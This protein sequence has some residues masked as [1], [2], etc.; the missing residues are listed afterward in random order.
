MRTRDIPVAACSKCNSMD[1]DGDITNRTQCHASAWQHDAVRHGSYNTGE[2]PQ[3]ESVLVLEL[4]NPARFMN[5]LSDGCHSIVLA[6]GSL[7]PLPSLCAELGFS[8]SPDFQKNNM[9]TASPSHKYPTTSLRETNQAGRLQ[10]R[11]PPLEADQVIDNEK[12]LLAVA[13]GHF[14]D[15]SDL[16]VTFKHYQH[17]YFLEKLGDAIATI[18][19]SIPTGGVLVFLPSYSFL[20]RC[21]Q[22]WNPSTSSCDHIWQRFLSKK[23][24]VVV[25]PTTGQTDFEVASRKYR[26][27]IESTN[28]CVLLAV[29]RG[30]MSEG[31]SFN[32]DFARGV[33]CVGIPFPNSMDRAV[34]AKQRYN[35]EQRKLK[36]RNELL[37]GNLWYKQ[38]A[39]R[40]IAQAMGRCIRHASDY[41]FVVLLDSRH[42][43]ESPP[44]QDGTCLAHQQLPKWMRSSV[45]TLSKSLTPDPHQKTIEGGWIGLQSTVQKFFHQAHRHVRKIRPCNTR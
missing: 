33:I 17:D 42:C 3:L 31:I 10:V 9:N 28:N 11:P 30:K 13:I 5:H 7:A 19:E 32:D 34:Q 1:M 38:Q 35:D 22:I 8:R 24:T 23:G 4:L 21:I 39:F 36:K 18:I 2:K 20:I 41:G 15:G 29:Y 26:E 44:G 16:T 40:A 37:P 14:P 25:E 45:K 6:S 27:T 43:D 12:Q